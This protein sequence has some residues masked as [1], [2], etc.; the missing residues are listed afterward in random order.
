M[1]PITFTGIDQRSLPDALVVSAQYAPHPIELGVLWSNTRAG[2]ENRY[3]AL[4]LVEAFASKIAAA[5][6]PSRGRFALHVCGSAVKDL[7]D[8][9]PR[10]TDIA[11][12]FDRV[13]VNL[14]ARAMYFN[15]EERAHRRNVQEVKDFVLRWPKPVIFQ[16]NHNNTELFQHLKWL[17]NVQALVDASGGQGLSPTLWREPLKN[18][19]TGYAGGLGPDNLARELAR[20]HE[21][22]T[23]AWVDMEGKLRDEQDWFS[24]ERA[25]ACFRAVAA[26]APGPTLPQAGD[27]AK[28][29]A[30]EAEGTM[31][32]PAPL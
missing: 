5:S 7:F 32:A 6:P 15:P 11:G 17:P 24:W 28:D 23:P 20:I 10:I 25:E 30:E 14:N 26:F 21:A 1:T 8:G 4:E 16:L 3:P 18:V 9:E 29:Q 27:Q 31:S 13:Q 2:I 12:A 19:P 22:A